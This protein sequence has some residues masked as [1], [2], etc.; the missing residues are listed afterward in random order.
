M[1]YSYEFKRKCVE[2]FR[3]GKEVTVGTSFFAFFAV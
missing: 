1:R 3:E 2:L